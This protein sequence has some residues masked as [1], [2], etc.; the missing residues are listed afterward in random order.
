LE[1]RRSST[2]QARP[3]VIVICGEYTQT[4]TGVN[5]EIRIARSEGRPYFLLNGR[6][7]GTYRKPTAAHESDKVYAW[8]WENLKKLIA[9]GR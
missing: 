2:H 3:A 6:P 5:E 8:T 1:G 9:G 4:A 7:N